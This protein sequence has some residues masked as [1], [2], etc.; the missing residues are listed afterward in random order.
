VLKKGFGVQ[1]I[2]EKIFPKSKLIFHQAFDSPQNHFIKIEKLFL[3]Q[4]VSHPN[5]QQL[6]A[7]L[8][9]EGI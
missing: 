5:I 8:W 2:L 9:Y 7:S 4:F 1:K 6:L 3:L